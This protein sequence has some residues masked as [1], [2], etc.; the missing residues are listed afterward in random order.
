VDDAYRG[1]RFNA[2]A[3]TIYSFA[4]DSLCDW[5][6]ELVK[7]RLE[8]GGPSAAAA[9]AT[10]LRVLGRVVQMLH[11]IAPHVTEEIASHLRPGA[12]L[13][14]KSRWE[15]SDF[16][17]PAARRAIGAVQDVVRAVRN[18]RKE[19]GVSDKEKVD[20]LVLAHA[21]TAAEADAL[22]SQVPLLLRLAL[23]SSIR[24]ESGATP[25]RANASQVLPF[26]DVFIDLEG[27]IDVAAERERLAR[28]IEKA[29][30]SI[31]ASRGKL[32]NESFVARAKPE[33]VSAERERMAEAES[34]VARLREH[35]AK[36]GG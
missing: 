27:K 18:L 24:V 33:V 26:A 11:P 29:A 35:L 22:R 20:V 23:A 17:D 3:Q 25:P 16:D 36:L 12:G 30:K 19:S 8:A 21:D 7:P 14:A 5:Y 32:S 1:Y 15:V 34:R 13:L 6:I 10:L 9:R 28:E 2:A 4:W 31:D